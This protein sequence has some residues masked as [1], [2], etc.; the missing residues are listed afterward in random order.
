MKLHLSGITPVYES[1]HRVRAKS[2]DYRWI[3]ARGKVVERD[4]TGNPLRVTGTHLDVTESKKIQQERDRLFR[5][6]MDML[7][8]GGFDGFFDQINPAWTRTFGWS[9]H[10]LL[11][12]PWIEFIHPDDRDET[13]F[14]VRKLT[15]GE[16]IHGFENRFQCCDGSYRWISWNAFP[17][18]EDRLVLAVVRDITERTR[19]EGQLRQA[20]K[21]EAIGRLAGG[22]AHDF[23]NLLTAIMGYADMLTRETNLDGMQREKLKQIGLAA[24]RA[25]R[26]TKQLLAF[27]RK[28]VMDLSNMDLNSVISNI[29]DMLKRLIGEDIRLNTNL[30]PAIG[31]VR[32]DP[33]LIGQVLMNLAVNARDAMPGGGSLHIETSNV[34]LDENYLAGHPDASIGPG[35]YALFTVSDT[36][37][38]MDA[39]TRSRIFDPFFTTKGSESGTGLGLSTVYGIV[40][41]HG[42]HIEVYS[43]PGQGTTFKVYLPRVEG[44][45]D[46]H[47]RGA[48]SGPVPTGR[49]TVLVVEDEAAL[50][51]LA[52][53]LLEMLGYRVLNA[54]TPEGA[55][56][57]AEEYDG[58]IHLLLTDVVLPG[59]DG[60][61]LFEKLVLT[62]PATKV[63]YVSGYTEN[64]IVHHGVLDPG[65]PFLAKPFTVEL[66]AH[67][68]RDILNKP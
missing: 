44:L 12:K 54:S 36:G 29:G 34:Y 7:C 28:Q 50:R 35:E 27:S 10:E 47:F 15:S 13:E 4:E 17:L 6:S 53:E 26:L 55:L 66:L 33:G 51:D 57:L 32:A 20:A 46:D 24:Q 43:E 8:I 56:I 3:V 49:E 23:N 38:G 62:R 30:D 21:M 40:K 37:T 31:L 11:S 2:G 42:G 14:T 64:F 1:E 16:P 52:C 68:I 39:N 9:E 58:P 67:K 60:R 19:L 59:M 41:Q 5:L 48:A 61:S 25:A 45:P 18:I 63:L 22:V 65:I